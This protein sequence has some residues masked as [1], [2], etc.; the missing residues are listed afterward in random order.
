VGFHLYTRLLAS[1]VRTLRETTGLPAP[2]AETGF[3]FKEARLPVSVDLPM[4]IGI[5]V[6][7]V[8]DQNMRLRLYRRLADVQNEV[9]IDALAEEFV[10]RFG[11]LPEPVD[12]LFYQLKVKMRA[13]EAGLASVSV[14]NDQIVL[15]YPALP[16]HAPVRNLPYLGPGIRAGKNAY[17]MPYTAHL[18]DWRE[19]LL[20][21]LS[22]VNS[23]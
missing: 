17:W 1:A 11:A 21:A 7:Y 3:A 5:P 6:D 13:E 9:D 22:A 4:S 19:R 8:P 14:E 20:E 16:E 10:D 23:R 18:E 2:S 12:N 15:R